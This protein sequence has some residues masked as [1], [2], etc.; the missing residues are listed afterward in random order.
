MV[1]RYLVLRSSIHRQAPLRPGTFRGVERAPPAEELSIHTVDGQ[2][3]DIGK[4]REDPNNMLVL[5]ADIRLS[6]IEPRAVAIAD[7]M[8]LKATAGQRCAP[9]LLA[10]GGHTT[11]FTGQGVTV[12]LLDT[13]I[14]RSH[15]A[16]AAKT[17]SVKNF[18]AEGEDADVADHDGHGT[19]C[20]GTVCG[21][22]VGGIRVGVAP[23]LTKLCIGKVLGKH[24]GTAEMMI[25]G[26]VWAVLEQK[27]TIVC[28]SLGYDLPGNT[29]RLTQRGLSIAQAANLVLRQ[30]A[31]LIASVSALRTFLRSQSANVMLIAA[32]GNESQRPGLVLDAGLPAAELFAVGAVGA[33]AAGDSWQVA[34]FSNGRVRVVAPGV[35]VVSSAVG[36]GWKSMSGTSMATPHVAGVAALW[37]EKA[38]R[39]GTLGMPGTVLGSLTANAT[40]KPLVDDDVSATGA[41]LVQAPQS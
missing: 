2:A 35:D 15:P 21:E 39:E 16:F 37:F 33:V 12:A 7:A 19:H 6:L 27:A 31:D 13:G 3:A 23:G 4:L 17:L 36:G 32:S 28:M 34:P 30:H 8:A 10:V 5:E 24:G 41:G 11:P 29:E 9:G 20:A 38:R 22:P 26:M 1:T 18:T 40:R 25:R 14:D